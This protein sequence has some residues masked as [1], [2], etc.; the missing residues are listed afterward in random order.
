M[1]SS[2]RSF[3]QEQRFHFGELRTQLQEMK[4][5]IKRCP[6]VDASVA[7]PGAHRS[8][9]RTGEVPRL[10]QIT[11]APQPSM[12]EY[13]IDNGNGISELNIKKK[14]EKEECLE[15]LL[16]EH[17]ENEDCLANLQFD[18]ALS[19]APRL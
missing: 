1:S 2:S 6:L 19:T 17:I 11:A 3:E 12:K 13:G 10:R 7:N 18:R 8:S 9:R 5:E 14:S 15:T 4:E 16:F